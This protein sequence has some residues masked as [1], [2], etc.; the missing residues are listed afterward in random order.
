MSFDVLTDSGLHLAGDDEYPAA[1]SRS[2]SSCRSRLQ[3]Y[4]AAYSIVGVVFY[5]GIVGRGH[6]V[7]AGYRSEGTTAA[8][9]TR[10]GCVGAVLAPGVWHLFD[11]ERVTRMST[12]ECRTRL[13][14]TIDG[15]RPV[16]LVL[17]RRQAC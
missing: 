13:L 17:R 8:A 2:S 15:F 14:G 4:L 1:R 3:E 11:D 10:R 16:V 7:S 9:A 6:Y 12:E 5:K